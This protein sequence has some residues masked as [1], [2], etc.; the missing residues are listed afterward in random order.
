MRI[1]FNLKHWNCWNKL[2]WKWLNLWNLTA[3]EIKHMAI[4]RSCKWKLTVP[5]YLSWGAY[6]YMVNLPRWQVLMNWKIKLINVN[7]RQICLQDLQIYWCCAFHRS[8]PG[9]Q[10]EL[11]SHEGWGNFMVYKHIFP[12]LGSSVYNTLIPRSYYV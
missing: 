9:T 11:M 3:W 5:T 8:A 10:S 6:P 12:N 7:P 2:N 1:K 4:I